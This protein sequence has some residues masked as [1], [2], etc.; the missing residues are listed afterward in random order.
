MHVEEVLKKVKDNSSRHHEKVESTP[1]LLERKRVRYE[2]EGEISPTSSLNS[3]LI[4]QSNGRFARAA[5]Q[6]AVAEMVRRKRKVVIKEKFQRADVLRQQKLDDLSSKCREKVVMARDVAKRVKAARILQR[7][8]RRWFK[9]KCPE[10]LLVCSKNSAM[11]ASKS[12]LKLQIWLGWRRAVSFTRY[13]DENNGDSPCKA[14]KR[15]FPEFVDMKKDG[16]YKFVSFETCS[17]TLQDNAVIRDAALFIMALK[18]LLNIRDES[19]V[20]ARSFLSA[21][22]I[23][24]YPEEVLGGF[25]ENV[26]SKKLIYKCASRVVHAMSKFFLSQS[27][28]ITSASLVHMAEMYQRFFFSF[29]AWRG[30]D[31]YKMTNELKL[32]VIQILSAFLFETEA[33][34]LIDS[35]V[36]KL[37]NVNDYKNKYLVYIVYIIQCNYT[38]AFVYYSFNSTLQFRSPMVDVIPYIRLENSD[39]TK[40]VFDRLVLFVSV[41]LLLL[42]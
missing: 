42:F 36:T 5:T 26:V 17:A 38:W 40:S 7:A 31:I 22:L 9:F 3:I 41:P 25:S 11:L 28:Q 35:M 4:P 10:V 27:S 19:S 15:L 24:S 16:S 2:S 14:L 20:Q 32:S 30:A 21:F 18:P 29:H 39:D 6:R 12:A 33:V 13:F 23:A 8:F 37:E 34:K 1:S